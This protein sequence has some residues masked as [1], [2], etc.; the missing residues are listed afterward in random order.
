MGLPCRSVS[1]LSKTWIVSGS[2]GT[3][4]N[5]STEAQALDVSKILTVRC[6]VCRRAGDRARSLG[7]VHLATSGDVVFVP[8]ERT[9]ETYDRDL[10]FLAPWE[11]ELAE[12]IERIDGDMTEA[13]LEVLVSRYVDGPATLVGTEGLR[14]RC[15]AGHDIGP[16]VMHRGES[17]YLEG[18]P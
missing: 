15:W 3:V 16:D 4:G 17:L 9:P 1:A 14:V 12:R 10:A 2:R 7:T 8:L 11:R 13:G 18:K 6:E 5:M